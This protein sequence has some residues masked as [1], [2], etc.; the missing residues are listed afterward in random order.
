MKNIEEKISVILPVYNVEKYLRKCLDS[1]VDQ[2][3]RNIEILCV[4]DGSTDSS[5][6]I[7]DEYADKDNRVRILTQKNS[8]QGAARNYGMDEVAGTYIIFVDSDDWCDLEMCEK[9]IYTIQTFQVDFVMCGATVYDEMENRYFSNIGYHNLK[10][11]SDDQE[12]K[13]LTRENVKES[14]FRIPVMPW[15]KIFRTHFLRE[16]NIRFIP[17]YTFEDNGFFCGCIFFDEKFCSD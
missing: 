10:I 6:K 13:V 14:T 5:R 17:G 16:Q 8:G 15:A 7:L 4:D 11:F 2:T 12:R 1:L 3:Y 9:L